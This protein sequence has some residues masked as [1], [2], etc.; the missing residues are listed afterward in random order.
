MTLTKTDGWVREKNYVKMKCFSLIYNYYMYVDVPDYLADQLFIKHRAR[1]KFG[2]EWEHPE[3]GYRI[4]FCRCFKWQ[5]RR[6]LNALYDLHDLM[7][8]SGHGDYE[9]FCKDLITDH[10]ARLPKSK[11]TVKRT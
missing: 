11:M 7:A 10:F 2:E 6:F 1:M 4:I 5:N 8:L 9:D 3:H